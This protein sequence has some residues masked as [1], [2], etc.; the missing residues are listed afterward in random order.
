MEGPPGVASRAA[1][2]RSVESWAV[3]FCVIW[4]ALD[5]ESVANGGLNTR[6][7]ARPAAATAAAGAVLAVC[8]ALAVWAGGWGADIARADEA[9]TVGAAAGPQVEVLSVP[10]EAKA[11]ELR[12]ETQ[13]KPLLNKYCA[14]CHL[15]G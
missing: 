6:R 13:V 1:R 8:A 3:E 9:S 4:I 11:I 12:Y 7:M 14:D 5:V 2:A 10:A 15:D